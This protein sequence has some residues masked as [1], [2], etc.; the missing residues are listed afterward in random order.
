MCLLAKPIYIF[1]VFSFERVSYID[2]FVSSVCFQALLWAASFLV[3]SCN[4]DVSTSSA[5]SCTY[6]TTDPLIKQFLTDN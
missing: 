2:F 4:S 1:T 5:G 6:L 3:A